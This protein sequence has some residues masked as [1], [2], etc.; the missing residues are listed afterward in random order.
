VAVEIRAF[1]TWN[2]I[3]LSSNNMQ[4]DDSAERSCDIVQA[5]QSGRH[6]AFEELYKSFG[7]LKSYFARWLGSQEASDFYHDLILAVLKAIR[8]GALREPERLPGFIKGTAHNLTNTQL[9]R[10]KLR[11]W[12]VLP[13]EHSAYL[14]RA[15]QDDDAIQREK[16][17][18]A[19]SALRGLPA[20]ERELLIRFYI[21]EDDRATICSDLGLSETQFRLLKSRAKARLA[22]RVQNRLASMNCGD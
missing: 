14:T 17:R 12:T 13:A 22:D 6:E 10:A 8:A 3:L 9:R 19:R 7:W 4:N 5:I 21:D 15:T 11:R 16:Q 20:R 2:R 1:D 18:D